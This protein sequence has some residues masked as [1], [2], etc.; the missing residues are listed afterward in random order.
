M[1]SVRR[2]IGT[3]LLA[4][5]STWLTSCGRRTVYHHF[6][7]TPLTGWEKNDAIEYGVEPMA[8]DCT[9]N[10]EV[11]LRTNALYPFQR[12]TLV[13]EQEILPRRFIRRDT[14]DYRIA[15][16]EGKV[17]G[18][19]MG[20]HSFSLP[21][22]QLQLSRG[23]SLHISLRHNMKREIL[24]GVADIGIRLRKQY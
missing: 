14:I 5:A 17:V 23:D 22:P 1:S 3:L 4:I 7:H 20:L 6:E 11:V 21:L 16:A 8:D 10:E 2:A 15:D 13:L 9:L 18:S 24:P 19:G 12:L